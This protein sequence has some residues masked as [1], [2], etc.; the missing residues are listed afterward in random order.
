MRGIDKCFVGV[1]SVVWIELFHKVSELTVVVRIFKQHNILWVE[2]DRR[3]V[4]VFV[5][6]ILHHEYDKDISVMRPAL[7]Y[8]GQSIV[9]GIH[10]VIKIDKSIGEWFNFVSFWHAVANV[11]TFVVR[12]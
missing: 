5:D 1:A 12:F 6:K 10:H 9:D 8:V 3:H 7:K 4:L 2:A 11:D